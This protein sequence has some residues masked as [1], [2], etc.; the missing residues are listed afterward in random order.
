[1]WRDYLKLHIIIFLW[2]FTAIVG[3]WISLSPMIVVLYRT[4]I[5]IAGM[6]VLL[7]WHQEALPRNRK[8]I[9]LM[10]LTGGLVA[11]HWWLFFASARVSTVSIC[12][13]GLAS[14][15]FWTSLLAPFFDR[16]S[17]W[18]WYEM[19]LGAVVVGAMYAIS[20][21]ETNYWYI[22][23]LLMGVASALCASLFTIIN[24]QFTK[25]YH[26]FSI[27][28]Y[29][30][31]GAMITSALLVLVSAVGW[32]M[33]VDFL[34]NSDW[35]GWV[36]ATDILNLLFLGGVCTVYAYSTSVELMRRIPPFAVNLSVNLEPVYGIVL[37]AILFSEWREM[38]A[39]FYLSAAIILSCVFVYP[40]IKKWAE[41]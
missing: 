39:M 19:L 35:G 31:V 10:L 38:T 28:F 7:Y 23:G 13:V 16:K 15:A 8:A 1:M 3:V 40:F 25:H 33:P 29:E 9:T 12:L 6:G 14:A 11:L 41:S 18:R 37:A 21:F 24:G 30:M 34:P 32:G 20:H 36:Y 2:G 27:T 22:V 17:R 26:H 4:L 5:A